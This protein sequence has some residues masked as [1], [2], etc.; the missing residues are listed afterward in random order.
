MV[1]W[2]PVR[3]SYFRPIVYRMPSSNTFVGL[4][5]AAIWTAYFATTAI[6]QN[7][8]PAVTIP[9]T[10]VRSLHSVATGRDYEPTSIFRRAAR[11]LLTPSI[12]SSICSTAS[13]TSSCS[14]QIQGGLLYDNY[15]PDVIVVGITYT[16]ASAN[17]DSLRAVDYTPVASQSNRGSATA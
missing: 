8:F 6:A 3:E 14:R 15:V 12:L 17:Y 2:I 7:T 4:A 1:N 5:T 13:G 11:A 9:N 10:E 16:G